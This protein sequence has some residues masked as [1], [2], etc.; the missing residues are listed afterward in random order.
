[1]QF[2]KTSPLK[3]GE[4]SEKSSGENRVKSCHVCGWHGFF[5]PE[6][7]LKSQERKR[8][9]NIN[10]FGRWPLRWPGGSPDREARGQSFMYYPR[11]PRNINLFVRM[12]D[13]EDRWPG[14]PERVLCAKVLCA[15]SAP[16]K[17]AFWVRLP[18]SRESLWGHSWVLGPWKVALRKVGT[19]SFKSASSYQKLEVPKRH[20][21]K[22]HP[23][24]LLEFY[25]NF[26][27]P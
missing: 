6:K 5:G 9:I 2:S 18:C 8:H 14:R 1:M 15:F 21:P 22:G 24:N 3:S 7:W 10:I 17:V 25:L 20:P 11:N 19:L 26:L 12:P 23:Q 16:S 27:S 4:S 13:R